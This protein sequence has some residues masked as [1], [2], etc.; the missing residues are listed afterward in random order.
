MEF[1]KKEYKML[2][3]SAKRLNV[4]FVVSKYD[5]T[6]HTATKGHVAAYIPAITSPDCKMVHVS[7][8]YCAKEDKFKK[9]IGKFHAL[10]RLLYGECVQMPLGL[11]LD[12]KETMR[13]QL[14][15]CFTI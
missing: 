2:K 15:W 4:K 8:S 12:D 1:S 5:S 6:H 3:E 7:V 9:R 11:Y 14:D 13:E 10:R